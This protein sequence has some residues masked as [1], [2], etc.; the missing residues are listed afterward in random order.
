MTDAVRVVRMAAA[1]VL[2]PAASELLESAVGEPFRQALD[3]HVAFQ[4]VNLDRP[5][6]HVNLGFYHLQMGK[7]DLAEADYR[8]ALRIAPWSVEASTNLADLYR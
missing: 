4:R 1:R 3:E 5:W 6:A 7:P 2:L 8:A